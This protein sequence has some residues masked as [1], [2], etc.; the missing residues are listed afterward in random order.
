MLNIFRRNHSTVPPHLFGVILPTGSPSLFGIILPS[1]A[2]SLFDAILLP[3]VS[4]LCC[5]ASGRCLRFLPKP[6]LTAP[7]SLSSRILPTARRVFPMQYCHKHSTS[8]LPICRRNLSTFSS[9]CSLQAL[10]VFSAP[11][12]V[13][14]LSCPFLERQKFFGTLGHGPHRSRGAK[15]RICLPSNICAKPARCSPIRQPRTKAD[16]DLIFTSKAEK[17]NQ[18]S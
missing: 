18:A 2:P 5:A 1:C 9:H 15:K 3:G 17:N 10:H 14:A 7:C 12:F 6:F 8:L 4:S 16:N 13:S 11:C